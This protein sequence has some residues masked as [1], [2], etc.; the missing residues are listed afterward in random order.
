M[1]DVQFYMVVQS[2]FDLYMRKMRYKHRKKA[3]TKLSL[4]FMLKLEV[5]SILLCMDKNVMQTSRY[6]KSLVS[7]FFV[8]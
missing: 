2:V 4:H 3:N 8:L 1:D 6:R 7:A 5:E